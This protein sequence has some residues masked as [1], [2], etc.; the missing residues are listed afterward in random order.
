MTETGNA[1]PPRKSAGEKNALVRA[2]L[3]PLAP[4]ERPTALKVAAIYCALLPTG[5]LI[6]LAFGGASLGTQ[7]KVVSVVFAA[8]LYAVAFGMWRATYGALITFQAFLVLSMVLGAFRLIFATGWLELLALLGILGI[9][10]W[11]F[12][13]LIR[14][15]GRI[16]AGS[17]P[18]TTE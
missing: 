15:M 1:K 2:E 4:G 13:K 8:V 18:P 7:A 14:I 6:A 10:G 12:W 3:E 11:L 17:R 5:N 9:S 16:Q